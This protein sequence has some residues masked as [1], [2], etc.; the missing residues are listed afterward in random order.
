MSSVKS[1]HSQI[2]KAQPVVRT[3]QRRWAGLIVLCGALFLE[4]MN[5]SSINVQIPTLRE[6]LHLSTTTA[7]FV[8]SAYLVTY[9]GFLLLGGRAADLLGRRRVFISGVGLFGLAS[10]AGGLAGEPVLLIVARAVQGIGAAFTAPAAMSII[11][12]TFAEGPERNKALGIYGGMGASGFAVGAVVSGVLTSALSWRWGFFDYAIIVALVVLLT[13][14]LV[15]KSPRSSETTR[16]FDLAGAL[17]VTAGLLLIVYTIGEANTVPVGQTLG[18]LVLAMLLLVAFVVIELRARVPMLPLGIFRSRTLTIANLVGFTFPAAFIGWLFIA[19]LYLQNVLGYS[20]FQAG[21]AFVPMGLLAVITANLTPQLI[22]RLGVKWTLVLAMLLMTAGVALTALI[23][24]EGTFWNIV[25]LSLPIG[26]GISV[27]FPSMT[28]AAVA[29]VQDSDQ[30][31]A[32]GLV[33]TSQQFGGALGLALV[34]LLAAV[35]T[36][37]ITALHPQAG[38]INQALISGFR[39]AL[40]FAAAFAVLGMLL[41]LGGLK[42]S[43]LRKRE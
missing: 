15:A 21:L 37:V 20:P 10:L 42:G 38:A 40:L 36:P 29:G 7:Q 12:T 2:G 4:T 1:T 9:A 31:L 13:P 23:L 39:P 24:T 22:N 14:A 8:I 30:G 17:L 35:S 43:T 25:L 28:L 16:G 27:A 6:N 11:T 41:A 5:L 3:N 34:T 19:T 18:Y 33:V 32:S 26:V